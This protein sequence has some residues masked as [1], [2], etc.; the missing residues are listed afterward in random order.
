MGG[1]QKLKKNTDYA[2]DLLLIPGNV[3][4]KPHITNG[5][6]PAVAEFVEEEETTNDNEIVRYGVSETITYDFIEEWEEHQ[7]KR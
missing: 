3:G 4:Y 6:S 5:I 7:E 2:C 1:L